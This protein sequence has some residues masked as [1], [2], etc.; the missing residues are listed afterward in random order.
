[1]KIEL[2]S[3]IHSVFYCACSVHAIEKIYKYRRICASLVSY[4][5]NVARGSCYTSPSISRSYN[6]HSISSCEQRS[7]DFCR[8]YSV[9]T[10]EWH[11]VPWEQTRI[12]RTPNRSITTVLTTKHLALEIGRCIL[13][14][15]NLWKFYNRQK[16]LFLERET[17]DQRSQILRARAL[18]P[19]QI[20]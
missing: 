7:K 18:L 14:I 2:A 1:M 3:E 9:G 17:L 5:S 16:S 8:H 12:M 19:R 20:I 13:I 6:A 15:K 10:C 4:S 11:R